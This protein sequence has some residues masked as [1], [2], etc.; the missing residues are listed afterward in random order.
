VC[1]HVEHRAV[2][3]AAL[4]ARPQAAQAVAVV[5]GALALLHRVADAVVVVAEVAVGEL[6]VEQ[7]AQR[8]PPG[9]QRLGQLQ[10]LEQAPVPGIDVAA[11]VE[12]QHALGQALQCD[13]KHGGLLRQQ[14]AGPPRLLLGMLQRADVREQAHR[15]ELAP[16]GVE[17]WR[18]VVVAVD[19]RA[20]GAFQRDLVAAGVALAAQCDVVAEHRRVGF[21]DV[22]E[23]ARAQHLRQR[24]AEH[25]AHGRV[26]IGGALGVVD[27]PDAFFG[28][29]EQQRHRRPVGTQRVVVGSGWQGVGGRVH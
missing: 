13:F 4:V 27:E 16:V 28:E 26:G 29:V 10:Q 24:A 15:A 21:V 11:G 5:V 12:A 22:I 14:L 25:A 23:D 6:V 9:H 8:R 7:H 1:L 20:I 3:A 17:H 2:G 19:R 18:G